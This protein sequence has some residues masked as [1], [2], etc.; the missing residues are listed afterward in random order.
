M[1]ATNA[2]KIINLR[3]NGYRPDE[4]ILVSLVGRIDEPNHTVF[5]DSRQAYDW[6][7]ARGLDICVYASSAV[8]W[9]GTIKALADCRPKLLALWD[10]DRKEGAEFWMLPDETTIDLPSNQWRWKLIPHPWCA[11]ENHI[12]ESD[13]CN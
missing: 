9:F 2:A 4:L 6:R 1:I 10:V 12:F 7:W 11:M 13:A 3:A 8:K 5:A